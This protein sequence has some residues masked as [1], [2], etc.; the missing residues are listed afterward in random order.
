MRRL[1]CQLMCQASSPCAT[2]WFSSLQ[3]KFEPVPSCF[4][5]LGVLLTLAQFKSVVVTTNRNPFLVANNK[6]ASL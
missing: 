5:H 2:V 3:L 4:H 1:S 6:K